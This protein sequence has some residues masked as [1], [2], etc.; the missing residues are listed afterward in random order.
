MKEKILD[1]WQVALVPHSRVIKD[2]FYARTEQ[3]IRAG[4]YTIVDAAVPGCMELDLM[5]AGM[6]DDLYYGAN[7]LQAQRLES[8]HLWYFSRFLWQ[9]IYGRVNTPR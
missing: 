8:T 1:S 9:D 6:L 2:P 7:I 3:E 4:G 5:R